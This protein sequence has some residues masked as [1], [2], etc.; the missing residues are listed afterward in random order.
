MIP[1]SLFQS[2]Q[3]WVIFKRLIGCLPHVINHYC[4]VAY[5]SIRSR[6]KCP[7][8]SSS[9][10]LHMTQEP[11]TLCHAFYHKNVARIIRHW[12][13]LFW[14]I[15]VVFVWG[16]RIFSSS[17]DY[18]ILKLICSLQKTNFLL[19]KL[20]FVVPKEPPVLTI[21]RCCSWVG[22]PWFSYVVLISAPRCWLCQDPTKVVGGA[23]GL[24]RILHHLALELSPAAVWQE[25]IR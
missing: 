6:F 21:N 13:C 4:I 22:F 25:M 24:Y 9:D 10:S 8:P 5:L 16:A 23:S 14:P 3:P 2:Y 11:A 19:E 1:V 7:V 18:L 15:S 12:I 17:P 20:P